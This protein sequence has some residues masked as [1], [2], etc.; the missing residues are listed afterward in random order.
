MESQ[1]QSSDNIRAIAN[2]CSIIRIVT[3]DNAFWGRRSAILRSSR[4]QEMKRWHSH[5]VV[6]EMLPA[7]PSRIDGISNSVPYLILLV[8]NWLLPLK[9]EIVNCLSVEKSKNCITFWSNR[10]FII[11]LSSI[12]ERKIVSSIVSGYS[13]HRL[14]HVTILKW[15]KS[16]KLKE[17]LLYCF[18]VVVVRVRRA[19]RAQWYNSRI[20]E[21][22][23]E[24]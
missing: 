17:N 1:E 11:Y 15:H 24:Y 8:L 16:R 14:L 6:R 12:F 23:F 20:S 9:R 3:A 21:C 22:V 2:R 4:S 5:M 13:L 19:K 10:T 7:L 18:T